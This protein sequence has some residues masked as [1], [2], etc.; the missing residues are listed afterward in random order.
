MTAL[1]ESRADS[2]AT[3]ADPAQVRAPSLLGRLRWLVGR[4]ET[5]FAHRPVAEPD[6]GREQETARL[7]RLEYDPERAEPGPADTLGP[8]AATFG[9]DDVDLSL[10]VVAA[11]ADLDANVALAYGLLS[12]RTG[13]S[14]A[15]VGL[16]LER[17]AV[18][19]RLCRGD[20]TPRSQRTA[21]PPRAAGGRG[22]PTLALPG[23]GRSRPR[24][25]A[26]ARSRRAARPDRQA[27]PATGSDQGHRLAYARSGA[28]PRRAA[29]LDPQ[30]TGDRRDRPGGG[31]FRGGRPASALPRPGPG[32]RRRRPAAGGTRRGNGG[33]A[34]R[35]RPRARRSR[36]ACRGCRIG[37]IRGHRR[38]GRAGC[39]DRRL[40]LAAP[41]APRRAVR[42]RRADHPAGRP[43]SSLAAHR[44]RRPAPQPHRRTPAQPGTD[45]RHRPDHSAV[46]ID[47]RRTHH[48][49][50]RP[51]GY[52]PGGRIRRVRSVHPGARRRPADRWV[53]R[54]GAPGAR[55]GL[56]A[57]VGLLG[58]ASGGRRGGRCQAAVRGDDRRRRRDVHRHARAPARR[59][60]P[61]WSPTQLGLDLFQVDLSAVVDKYI[62]ETE[63]NLERV[64][65]TA[66][67]LN[68]VLFFDE[69][70]ALFGNR[71]EVRDARD[72]YANQEVAYLLQRMEHF[73]GIT[74]LATNLRGNLDPAFSRRM[75]LHRALPRPGR[76]D[77]APALGRGTSP[78]S[79]RRTRPT[80]S[81]SPTSRRR[82]RAQRR[83][84]PQHRHRGRLRRGGRTA[85][86]RHA[87]CARRDRRRVPQARET[88]SRPSVRVRSRL[89]SLGSRRGG[90]LRS[91]AWRRGRMEH[92]PKSDK[93]A[94]RAPVTA[95]TA[96]IRRF[97]TAGARAR[98]ADPA[99]GARPLPSGLAAGIRSLSGVAVD[100]VAVHTDAA[101]P[102]RARRPR[103]HPRPRH[104]RRP[105]PG[106][107]DRARGLARRPAGPG[108]HR[109]QYRR[110]TPVERRPG[111]RDWKR[112]RW[113]AGR[114]LRPLTGSC[115]K[116]R[117]PPHGTAV[118]RES[119][120]G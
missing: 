103:L 67:S 9:L 61:T 77:P 36:P 39:G 91:D 35:L 96:S 16:A 79:V 93:P 111:A 24:R 37:C 105:R 68:V 55:T 30:P 109:P 74:I 22:W 110:R 32:D 97:D 7:L 19:D 53:R 70:D 95:V 50:T 48:P 120:N 113:A 104:L 47:R 27:R 42:R 54:P 5:A 28:A 43:G 64:F 117:L 83:R 46:R 23:H 119:F 65:A 112:G 13:R 14:R 17:A 44:R 63:K 8:L 26:P 56:A 84:H 2:T 29:V 107:S 69:A 11:G 6:S 76:A 116:P 45:R 10:L 31:G 20:G 3:T 49:G 82:R 101:E 72:R 108:R 114:P 51:R 94:E 57:P 62:G 90:S 18:G 66:E 87:A 118:R 59:W 33:R 78:R 98:T 85:S 40:R 73:D 99:T 52:P 106:R 89:A 25:R 34:A 1:G 4:I 92:M 100:D 60:P 81:T 15:T 41:L 75:Q 86:A 80:R 58:F 88:H 38:R 12:G 102:R 71:S 21:A 115:P